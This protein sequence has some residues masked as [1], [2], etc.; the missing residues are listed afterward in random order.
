MLFLQGCLGGMFVAALQEEGIYLLFLYSCT[1]RGYTDI[2]CH[3]R[4][5]ASFLLEHSVNEEV[6]GRFLFSVYPVVPHG[7]PDRARC[8]S[9]LQQGIQLLQQVRDLLQA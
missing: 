7:K 9:G 1:V 3:T 4:E 2:P 8:S 5:I 6:Q